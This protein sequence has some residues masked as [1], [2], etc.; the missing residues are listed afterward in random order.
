MGQ[1]FLA[2]PQ[3]QLLLVQLFLKLAL[4]QLQLVDLRDQ[5]LNLVFS[6][7]VC[8]RFGYLFFKLLNCLV[9]LS[10]RI[11]NC[12]VSGGERI[13]LSLHQ[14]AELLAVLV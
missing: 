9:A 1:L 7:L 4:S 13:S 11:L 2:L 8:I 14:L 12:I 3:K 6:I 10:E 5:T